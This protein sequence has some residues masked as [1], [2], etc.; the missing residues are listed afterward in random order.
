MW[1]PLPIIR[2]WQATQPPP[3]PPSVHARTFP[4]LLEECLAAGKSY[5]DIVQA[6]LGSGSW[7][8]PSIPK[9][10]VAK[11]DYCQSDGRLGRDYV[12]TPSCLS[13]RQRCTTAG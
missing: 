13:F 2:A 8:F 1:L 6:E 11:G 10:W 3:R 5:Y 7:Y 12:T 9:P 4:A